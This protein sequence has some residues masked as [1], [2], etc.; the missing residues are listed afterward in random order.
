MA[1]FSY[2]AVRKD[3]KEKKGSIEAV[4]V[5]S[6]QEAL[7]A[8]GLV[9]ISVKTQGIL[10]KD[11][12]IVIGEK[13][14]ARD[15]SVFCRQFVSIVEAGVPLKS[16]MQMLEEQSENKYM[17]MAIKETLLGI[18][19][20]NTL[21]D[22][23]QT[24]S[25]VFPPMLINMVEAGEAS[26]SLELAFGRMALH[27]EKEAKLK[28]LVRKAMIYPIVLVLACVMVI[29]A[30]LG[31][32]IPTFADMFADIDME[33]PAITQ[34]VM[35]ASSLFIQYWYLFLLGI[36]VIIGL[37]QAFYR[38]NRGRLIIDDFKIHIP[39][40]GQLTVKT[41]CAQFARTAG[42]L[43]AAG[44]SMIDCLEISGKV[45]GNVH[46]RNALM[47]AREQVM[48]GIPVSE[49]LRES[50]V[51]PPMVYHMVGIGEETGN[52]EDMLNKLADY[53]EEEVEITTQ[54]VMAAIEPLIILLMALIVGTLVLAVIMPIASLYSGLETI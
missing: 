41:A 20:G 32:V 39:I 17:R 13:V 3:G 33:L 8:Q 4:D 30:M 53:Y 44:I 35:G 34:F 50:G 36:I 1:D 21:A 16:A 9:P 43:L 31:F 26:G 19:R 40:F 14:K 25:D 12:N 51:Y 49:P 42:T 6:A 54:T 29:I 28:A 46:F 5:Q 11:L 18:E 47:N 23:M 37:Y 7:K 24:Q 52:L 10:N 2:V 27:F 22:S 48:K 38:S 15:L 45:I